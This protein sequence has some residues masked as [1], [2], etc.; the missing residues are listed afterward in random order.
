MDTFVRTITVEDKL[1]QMMYLLFNKH[2]KI[3]CQIFLAHVNEFESSYLL[4]LQ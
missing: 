3:H 2:S 1:D 4:C